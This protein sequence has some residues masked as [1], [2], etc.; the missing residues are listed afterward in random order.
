MILRA[1]T[2]RCSESNWA[3]WIPNRNPG[4]RVD[5][6]HQRHDLLT[7][8]SSGGAGTLS[9]HTRDLPSAP[10]EMPSQRYT[11]HTLDSW[12]VFLSYSRADEDLA[13]R[14][15]EAFEHLGLKVWF[16]LQQAPDDGWRRAIEDGLDRSRSFVLITTQSKPSPWVKSELLW[17]QHRRGATPAEFPI[18]R[19]CTEATARLPGWDC[20][21]H[22]PT[23]QV[24]DESRSSWDTAIAQA[25]MMVHRAR[26]TKG[27]EVKE[28]E[29]S[30]SVAEPRIHINEIHRTWRQQPSD[31]VERQFRAAPG[32][33]E[34]YHEIYEA[35]ALHWRKRP[36][37][38]IYE[39]LNGSDDLEI[40]DFG[41][42]R[43]ELARRI[44]RRHRIHSFDYVPITEDVHAGDM[45][46]TPLNDHSLDR[47]V[48]ALSLLCSDIRPHLAEASRTLKP[49][50]QLHIIEPS[51]W[52][53]ARSDS[54]DLQLRQYGLNRE[55]LKFDWKFG[56]L[57]ASR[58][59]P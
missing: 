3:F 2:L 16:D 1:R 34:N 26:S 55:S 31:R 6:L 11:Q 29:Q 48:Y 10:R 39:S 46:K 17:A 35:H 8:P 5:G 7:D 20:Y 41:C 54:L 59:D 27:V 23:I 37:D 4:K 53:F 49:G 52:F 33:W 58:C 32:L 42:G 38:W 18:L 45:S 30:N 43:A 14:A 19:L 22:L 40:G 36:V 13:Q 28:S 25:T 24:L 21:R 51:R 57:V 47:A 15:V 44:G 50:G 9:I 12:D 56:H